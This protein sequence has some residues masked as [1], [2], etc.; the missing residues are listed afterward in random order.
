MIIAE[1]RDGGNYHKLGHFE[2]LCQASEQ[3]GGWPRFILLTSLKLAIATLPGTARDA[4]NWVKPERP[5]NR[6]AARPRPN[7]GGQDAPRT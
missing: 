3:I 4:A 7:P 5:A 2:T 1:T 6:G